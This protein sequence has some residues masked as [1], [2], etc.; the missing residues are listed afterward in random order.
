MRSQRK[1]AVVIERDE[2]G[3]DVGL[4]P[5]FRGCHTQTKTLSGQDPLI[6]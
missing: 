5:T 4:V 6:P 3:Y 2:G 1:F